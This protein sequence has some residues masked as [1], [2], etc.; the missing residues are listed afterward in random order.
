[1]HPLSGSVATVGATTGAR[2][3]GVGAAQP[4]MSLT[5]SELGER[6]GR[7]AEWIEART[8]IQRLRRLRQHEPL[9]DLAA[10][11][12]SSA[13]SSAGLAGDQLDLII[14]ATCS[15]RSGSA[16]LGPQLVK[17]LAPRAATFDLNAACSGFCYGVSIADSMIRA[18]SA[19]HVLVVG[20]E[21]MSGL[22]DP[23][24]LGTG[25]IFGDGAGAAVLGPATDSGLAIGP[26]A[27]GSD[28]SQ[29][30]LIAF[31]DGDPFMRMAGQQVFRWAVDKIHQVAA[32]AC[33][34]AGVLPSDIQLFIPHQANLRIVDAMAKKLG[35]AHAIVS[36][37]IVISGN[38]SAASI[39]IALT[40]LIQ[41][42]R[43]RTGDLALLVGFG[44]GLAYA[45]QVVRVP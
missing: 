5:G 11:A 37:D 30:G 2:L 16:P 20:A 10:D 44:A 4:P 42:G 21:R 31:P 28:G 24:D 8:G 3:M 13:L 25:I 29:A 27:W 34:K 15:T 41:S 19:R 6:F 14:A 45:A 33:Q 39:P 12:A 9:I 38:T 18:G 35:M 7:T 32:V 22:I 1:M 40:R 43:A 17:R 26:V 36:A 23:T